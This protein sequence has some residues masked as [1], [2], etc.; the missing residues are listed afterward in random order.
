MDGTATTDTTQIEGQ[1]P[2]LVYAMVP[3]GR[4]FIPIA[5]EQIE[6]GEWLATNLHI[7]VHGVGDTPEEAAAEFVEMALDHFEDY[8]ADRERLSPSMLEELEYLIHFLA[9]PEAV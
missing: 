4:A 1:H 3:P 5:L 2:S 7:L 8:S 9:A 6:T